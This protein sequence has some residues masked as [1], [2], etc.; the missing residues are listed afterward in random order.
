[1]C[2]YSDRRRHR[3]HMRC[4][5]SFPRLPDP[6]RQDQTGRGPLRGQSLDFDFVVDRVGGTLLFLVVEIGLR[7]IKR[8][9]TELELQGRGPEQLHLAGYLLLRELG[10]AIKRVLQFAIHHA[11][12][13][14]H[15]QGPP[16]GR[17]HGT[18]RAGNGAIATCDYRLV[19]ASP[20]SDKCIHQTVGAHLQFG[21]KAFAPASKDCCSARQS[22]GRLTLSLDLSLCISFTCIMRTCIMRISDVFLLT[23]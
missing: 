21:P 9:H 14:E 10:D 7:G 2:V 6:T 22:C 11:A 12:K 16:H 18:Q 13:G 15:A 20:Q 8:D 3:P 4:S 19:L 1:M 17:R 5:C 23:W